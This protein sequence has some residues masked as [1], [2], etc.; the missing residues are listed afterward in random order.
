MA[1]GTV[2]TGSTHTASSRKVVKPKKATKGGRKTKSGGKKQRPRKQMAM[3]MR[4]ANAR[5]P[6]RSST[7]TTAA[8][9]LPMSLLGNTM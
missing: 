4:A 5:N 2:H 1:D 6:V 8:A 3:R 9:N 7:A